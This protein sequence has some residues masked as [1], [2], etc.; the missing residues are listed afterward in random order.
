MDS[1]TQI[2]IDDLSAVDLDSPPESLEFIIDPPSNGHLALRRTP[3]RPVLSFTQAHIQQGQLV[4]VH[5]GKNIFQ[6]LRA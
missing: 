4:F 5:N 2:T 6:D 3:S 1:I